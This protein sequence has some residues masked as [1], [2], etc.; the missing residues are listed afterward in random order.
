MEFFGTILI[1]RWINPCSF[2]AHTGPLEY[3]YFGVEPFGRAAT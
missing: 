1:P 3:G 2:M